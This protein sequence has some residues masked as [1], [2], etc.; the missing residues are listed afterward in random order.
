MLVLWPAYAIGSSTVNNGVFARLF[1]AL[2]LLAATRL[3][4]G[5][6][7]RRRLLRPTLLFVAMAG[8]AIASKPTAVAVPLGL[9]IGLGLTLQSGQQRALLAAALLLATAGLWL[10]LDASPV[11][12]PSLASLVERLKAS[13]EP[14]FWRG[15]AG[16]ATGAFNWQSRTLPTPLILAALAALAALALNGAH[17]LWS[18][19]RRTVLLLLLLP[20]ALQLTIVLLRGVGIGRYLFPAMPVLA[21][22]IGAGFEAA[23]HRA[24]PLL[25]ALAAFTSIWLTSGLFFEGQ[26]LLGLP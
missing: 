26:M 14:T 23:P 20:L 21:L 11:T 7:A 16:T 17:A 3:L 15:L 12:A 1:S 19:E 13:L 5:L 25:I 4:A 9:A 10:S 2:A 6:Q 18:R 24:R 8:L 22:L